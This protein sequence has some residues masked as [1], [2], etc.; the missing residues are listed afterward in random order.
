MLYPHTCFPC[1][2]KQYSQ[3]KIQ[4]QYLLP[5][6]SVR[7]SFRLEDEVRDVPW[8][9]SIP[10]GHLDLVNDIRVELVALPHLEE[11]HDP[12]VL[13]AAKHLRTHWKIKVLS[14]NFLA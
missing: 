13:A 5:I 12:L 1:A 14:T 10:N 8:R 9:Q 2:R 11:Q 3:A 6:D 4:Q 7:N